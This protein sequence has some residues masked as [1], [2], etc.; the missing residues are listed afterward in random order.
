M[1][2]VTV[3][4]IEEESSGL[5]QLKCIEADGFMS[6]PFGVYKYCRYG[7]QFPV[8]RIDVEMFAGT[9]RCSAHIMD[10][11]SGVFGPDGEAYLILL[12]NSSR[13]RVTL[14][15]DP[16]RVVKGSE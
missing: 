11:V 8:A 9:I 14:R 13:Y 5:K 10:F 4:R 16:L 3:L 12:L 2:W 6:T 15:M 1:I 7:S